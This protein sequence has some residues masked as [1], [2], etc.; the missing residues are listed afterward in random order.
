MEVKTEEEEPAVTEVPAIKEEEQEGSSVVEEVAQQVVSTEEN[1][2]V[3]INYSQQNN[4][5]VYQTDGT[6]IEYAYQVGHGVGNG[7]NRVHFS[8]DGTKNVGEAAVQ[9]EY[10][11]SADVPGLQDGTVEYVTLAGDITTQEGEESRVIGVLRDSGGGLATD[12]TPI[13]YV[14]YTSLRSSEDPIQAA[15]TTAEV[16]KVDLM[17]FQVLNNGDIIYERDIGPPPPLFDP[18]DPSIIKVSVD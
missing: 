13:H 12:Y 14:P 18:Q 2:N 8:Q 16:D 11:G 1:S 15:L 10:I 17:Q 9:V 3:A 6:Y 5:L 7:R 4:Q